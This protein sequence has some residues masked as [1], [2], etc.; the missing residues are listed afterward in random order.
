M[1]SPRPRLALSNRSARVAKGLDDLKRQHRLT[2]S[3]GRVDIDRVRSAQR[4]ELVLRLEE[5]LIEQQTAALEVE[6]EK[7][8]NALIA[9]D[10]EVK[11]LEK[12]RQRQ[13]E[14]FRDECNRREM[15]ETDDVA[16]CQ[17]WREVNG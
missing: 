12:L 9:A 8:R 7:R 16:G 10:R 2:A 14:R 17:Y 4:Y 3:R 5:N 6:I 1:T 15:K 13:H 11:V